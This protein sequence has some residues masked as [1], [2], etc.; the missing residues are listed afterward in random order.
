MKD[1]LK[2]ILRWV[3]ISALIIAV[4]FWKK[5]LILDAFS[6]MK[7]MKFWVIAAC[8]I[9][10]VLY[11]VFDGIATQILS[12]VSAWNGI[13]S[14]AFC[15]FY[16]LVTLG[17]AAG[18]AEVVYLSRC[19]VKAEK[20]TGIMMI[21]YGI[22]KTVVT[23]LGLISFI[24]L[25]AIGNEQVEKY[26]ILVL[27]GTVV[28]LLIV[29]GLMAVALSEKIAKLT[30]R[31]IRCFFKKKPEK[32]DKLCEKIFL[33]NESGRDLSK[34]K[35]L[36]LLTFLTD[37]AK[38][39]SWYAIPAVIFYGCTGFS[40]LHSLML[41]SVALLLS[42]VMIA[43]AGIGTL[44]YIFSLLFTPIPASISAAAV[45]LYRFFSMIIPFFLGIPIV[46]LARPYLS[47]SREND[48]DGEKVEQF[49][50]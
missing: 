49:L 5:T 1:S 25:F 38:M 47:S 7:T 36:L 32:S 9:L 41:M 15:A 2:N 14:A 39:T 24:V 16:K 44:E 18:V 19:G 33:F 45:I 42:G 46:A 28:S 23:F 4:Y 10:S 6:Q 17:S 35:S 21:Q 12:G 3:I 8:F 26:K 34:K 29:A 11:I 13:K 50:S 20:A 48:G 31:I 27:V 30:A 37:C 40:I 22:H 43:P